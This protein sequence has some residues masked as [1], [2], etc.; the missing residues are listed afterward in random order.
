[1]VRN[2]IIEPVTFWVVPFPGIK[3]IDQKIPPISMSD[4]GP[5]LVKIPQ[6]EEQVVEYGEHP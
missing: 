6:K 3:I 5:E 2:N 1:M 4:P